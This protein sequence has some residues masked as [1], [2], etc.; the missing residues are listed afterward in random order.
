[1]RTKSV[2]IV[3]ALFAGGVANAHEFS[4]AHGT[5]VVDWEAPNISRVISSGYGDSFGL[6]AWVRMG[7]PE[8]VEV[9]GRQ[10]I[11][12]SY[13]LFDVDDDFDFD[14]AFDIDETVTIELLFARASGFE[15]Q[16]AV[17]ELAAKMIARLGEF[18][19]VAAD[20]RLE[21]EAW[22]VAEPLESM[23][24]EQR[25]QILE[26]VDQ[27]RRVYAVMLDQP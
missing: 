7:F 10:C 4:G 19:A 5:V 3:C 25:P 26:S 24:R 15:K 16:G 11:D 21:L 1:V 22:S 20:A 6:E 9:D 8:S 14:F 17:A 23:F 12:G 2:L 27:A 13:F 18:D